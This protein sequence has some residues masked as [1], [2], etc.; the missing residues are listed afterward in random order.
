MNQLRR[1]IF[2]PVGLPVLGTLAVQLTGGFLLRNSWCGMLVTD[3]KPSIK[4]I[5]KVEQGETLGEI[6]EHYDHLHRLW[7]AQGLVRKT[8]KMNDK[9][10]KNEGDFIFPGVLIELPEE[11]F[12]ENAPSVESR[13]AP[14][15]EPAPLAPPVEPQ[16]DPAPVILPKNSVDQKTPLLE[17]EKWAEG[18][19]TLTPTF[20]YFRISSTDS[21]VGVSAG[22]VS[23]L[24]PGLDFKWNQKWSDTTQTFLSGGLMMTKLQSDA[25]NKSVGGQSNTL[26]HM[27]MGVEESI[28]PRIKLAAYAGVSQELTLTSSSLTALQVDEN[29]YPKLGAALSYQLLEKKHTALDL[30]AGAFILAPVAT[31]TYDVKLGTGFELR[32]GLRQDLSASWHLLGGAGYLNET[33]NTSITTQSLSEI[34]FNFGFSYSY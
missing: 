12:S 33:Q 13:R 22:L 18:S 24:S 15:S 27:E 20:S 34:R 16:P 17:N 7:G 28:S 32:I 5:Y 29:F 14:A 30:G 11:L 26:S 23:T 6:L 4:H 31:D 21:A 2:S 1:I 10:V 8:W 3:H 9:I 19:L 25:L